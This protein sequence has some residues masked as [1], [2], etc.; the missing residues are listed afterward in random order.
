MSG[1]YKRKLTFECYTLAGTSISPTTAATAATV[2]TLLNE[3]DVL[4]LFNSCDQP[5]AITVDGVLFASLAV[6]DQF[7]VDLGPTQ[8]H[9]AG[10]AVIGAYKT[11][12]TTPTAGSV[13]ITLLGG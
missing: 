2:G 9:L 7:V 12:V 10:G 13:R 5:I 6:G 3:R 1:T 11:G 8:I 4:M